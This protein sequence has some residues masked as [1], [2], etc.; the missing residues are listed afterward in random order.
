LYAA[1][2]HWCYQLPFLKLLNICMQHQVA[3]RAVADLGHNAQGTTDLSIYTPLLLDPNACYQP[4][5]LSFMKNRNRVY[6]VRSV[7]NRDVTNRLGQSHSHRYLQL[8]RSI[9]FT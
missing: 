4:L 5:V 6:R 1:P 8:A 2:S 3:D 7:A 9:P